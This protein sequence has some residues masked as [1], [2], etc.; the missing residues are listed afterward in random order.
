MMTRQTLFKN[1]IDLK[2]CYCGKDGLKKATKENFKDAYKL[3]KGY[4]PKTQTYY[5]CGICEKM[6]CVRKD[7]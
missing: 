7:T 3:R 2:C 6:V 5:Y 1:N 4:H